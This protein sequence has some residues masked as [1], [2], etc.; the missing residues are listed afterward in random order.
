MDQLTLQQKIAEIERETRKVFG[1]H[2]ERMEALVE[3]IG[4]IDQRPKPGQEAPIFALPGAEGR[5]VQLSD[6]L[7]GRGAV[8][9]F[10]R[11]LWCPYCNAQ[12]AALRDAESAFRDA[13]LS[14][15][16]I[17][18]EVGG[19]ALETKRELHLSC[20]VLCDVDEGVALMYG[21]L[22]PV[23]PEDREFLI[24]AGYD[25][26][27]LYG[28]GAWF[29]PLASSFII[30]AEGKV[31]KV[32]GGTDQRQRADPQQMLADAVELLP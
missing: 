16:I 26:S 22:V 15:A 11:G 23:P 21:C 24:G 8:L 2:N 25:L 17:T 3:R 20:D 14:V 27:R 5:L 10:I 1:A 31:A 19:R 18:P 6:L 30:G 12:M 13:N 28:N 7:K 32:Y 4:Q 9:V 29:M